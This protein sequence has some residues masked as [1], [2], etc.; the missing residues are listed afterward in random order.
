MA[1]I[2]VTAEVEDSANWEQGFRTHGDLFQEYTA[3]S[4]E[5][6]N[7][8]NEVA[9]LWEVDDPNKMLSLMDE[10]ATAEAMAMD[11]VK[12]DTVKVYVLDKA[13]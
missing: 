11:G 13:F 2:I 8:N 3:T 7:E 9:I 4:I 1:R 12:R 6:K 5:F 10:P